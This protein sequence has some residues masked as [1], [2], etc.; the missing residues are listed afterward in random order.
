MNKSFLLPALSVNFRS[1]R[2]KADDNIFIHEVDSYY[3]NYMCNTF[4]E[5]S[6]ENYDFSILYYFLF[7]RAWLKA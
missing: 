4:I 1:K 3:V 6:F 7:S 2:K 5:G